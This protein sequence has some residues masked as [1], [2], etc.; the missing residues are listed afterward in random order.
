ML[1]SLSV[2]SLISEGEA[3]MET[4]MLPSDIS[5]VMLT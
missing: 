3:G 1:L 5:Y 4:E 2:A